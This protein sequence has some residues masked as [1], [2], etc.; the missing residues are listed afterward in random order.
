MANRIQFKVRRANGTTSWV[1]AADNV[2]S[3]NMTYENAVRLANLFFPLVTT[4]LD[5]SENNVRLIQETNNTMVDTPSTGEDTWPGTQTLRVR[6]AIGDNN[7]TLSIANAATPTDFD[8]DGTIDN[9]TYVGRVTDF[10]DNLA[11]LCGGTNTGA[12]LR[13]ALDQNIELSQ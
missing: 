12:T 9:A 13:T 8:T 5:S 11:T 4:A 3:S 7:Y 6:T 2:N 10:V 1:T